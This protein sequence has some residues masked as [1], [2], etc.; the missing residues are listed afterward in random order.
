MDI[1]I[2][3]SA[4]SRQIRIRRER[5]GLNQGELAQKMGV[6]RNS[7]V[8]MENSRPPIGI[9]TINAVCDALG[10]TIFSFFDDI[11]QKAEIPEDK[12]ESKTTLLTV[13]GKKFR[14]EIT[15]E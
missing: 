10:C 3:K 14:V 7:I 5:L 4:I 8:Q 6:S 1:K 2:L 9:S 11:R 13:K 15:A 12:K